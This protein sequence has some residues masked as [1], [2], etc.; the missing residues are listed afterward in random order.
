VKGSSRRIV[1]QGDRLRVS[2]RVASQL[3]QGS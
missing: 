3:A 2:I 1:Y